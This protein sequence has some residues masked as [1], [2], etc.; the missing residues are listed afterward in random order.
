[1]GADD[2][3]ATEVVVA[4]VHYDD[5]TSTILVEHPCCEHDT[6]R[7]YRLALGKGET[8]IASAALGGLLGGFD[9]RTRCDDASD[10]HAF[11]NDVLDTLRV[12]S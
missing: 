5:G 3:K 6:L 12:I 11:A 7:V 8:D 1:M 10:T 9:F 2:T 4:F